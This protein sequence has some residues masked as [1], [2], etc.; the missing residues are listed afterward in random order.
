[1]HLCHLCLCVCALHLAWYIDT[2]SFVRHCICTFIRHFS[3]HPI[4]WSTYR[5][6]NEQGTAQKSSVV[7]S[8][9]R[10]VRRI[11]W[12]VCIY[13]FWSIY[14]SLWIYVSIYVSA[15]Y[16]PVTPLK[17]P[18]CIWHCWL[19]D[20]AATLRFRSRFQYIYIYIYIYIIKYN[21]ISYNII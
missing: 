18:H 5:S 19:V 15:V 9:V 20:T 11:N 7:M 12:S 8:N 3:Y 21:I 14:I 17:Q 6:Q 13:G 4:F 1:M 2:Q 10:C 16:Q